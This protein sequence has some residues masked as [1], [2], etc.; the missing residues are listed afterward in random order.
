MLD[1]IFF[2]NKIDAITRKKILLRP[3]ARD[4]KLIR[5]TVKK[6]ISDVINFGDDALLKYTELFDK[7]KI[8]SF[9]VSEKKIFQS[10]KKMSINFKNAVL[11]AKRNIEIF[12][13]AQV[14]PFIDIETQ[15]GVNCKQIIVPI[16]SVGLYIPGGS[17][18]LFSTVLMLSIPAIIAGCKKIILCSPPP[19]SDE[20]L[21]VA[22]ICNIFDIYQIGGSQAIAAM[23]FGTDSIPKVN[24]IFGPGNA[25]VTE[26]KLQV[27]QMLSGAGIDMLAGPSEILI[28]A[29]DFANPDFIAS[30]L[31]SQAEHGADSQ[32]ILLTPSLKIVKSVI[33]SIQKQL[34]KLSRINILL[35]SLKN[36]IFIITKDLLECV[37]ISNL[38]GPE[39]LI[40][41]TNNFKDLIAHI[42]NAGSIFLGPWSPESVGDYASGT[43]HVLPTYGYTSRCSGLGLIDFQKRITVQELTSSGLLNLSSTVTLLAEFEKMEAHKNAVLIRLKK[44]QE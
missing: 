7:K 19:I 44:L 22:Y 35:E 36:S 42:N 18:S 38:Y 40:I 13:K 29:D 17:A 2:W 32:V 11:H 34:N 3:V 43:N 14:N 41:Q 25:Y 33:K 21:S 27:S 12:H 9:K 23:A 24:K 6:I 30:D 31:L 1:N 4:Q 10:F 16:N 5:T 39:H 15:S 26:A 20:I 8:I 28:I 37:F